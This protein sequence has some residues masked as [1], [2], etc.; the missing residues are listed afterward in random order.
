[1]GHYY[2]LGAQL[3]YLIYGQNP[4]M[5]S[6]TFKAMAWEQMSSSDAALLDFCTLDP[7]PP[8]DQPVSGGTYA[9]APPHTPSRF[10]NQWREWERSL[11]LNLARLR[12]VKLRREGT[13]EAPEYPAE[14]VQTAKSAMA[15]DSPLEAELFLDK[16]RWDAIESFQ[17]MDVFSTNAIYA[18]LLKLLLME[19]R[20]AFR[21]EEG[22]DQ[23]KGLYAAILGFEA[24]ADKP[25]G[26]AK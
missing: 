11:R 17:G 4:P 10:I 12:G 1:M 3:P 26:E 19:R 5:S 23:Y 16:A 20:Q 2:Y 6:L 7:D 25:I 13:G 14:A 22:Y 24:E 9:E 18:Y 8:G 21:A 15:I